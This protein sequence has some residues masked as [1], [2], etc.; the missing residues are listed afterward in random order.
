M[1]KLSPFFAFVLVFLGCQATSK[2]FLL[3]SIENDLPVVKIHNKNELKFANDFC[4]LF[5]SAT[6]KRLKII[7]TDISKDEVGV[8]LHL[9]S[10][11]SDPKIKKGFLIKQQKNTLLI[12]EILERTEHNTV[13][14]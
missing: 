10:Q 3:Y 11:L 8:V 13:L 7:E 9:V 14:N 4:D 6:S 1:R 2:D 12:E 5:E